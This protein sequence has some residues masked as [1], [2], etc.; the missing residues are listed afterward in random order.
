[1]SLIAYR[2]PYSIPMNPVNVGIIGLG[3]MG[4][5]YLNEF[6]KSDRWAVKTICELCEARHESIAA[7]A[8]EARIVT[9]E[10]EIFNDPEIQVVV[11][12]ALA[13]TRLRQIEKAV[14]AGK[15]IIAEKPIADTPENEWKAVELVESAPILSA[16][17]LYIRNSWYLN[18]LNECITSGEI[19][20]LAIVRICHMTPGLSPGEGH[21]AEGPAFHDCGMHYVD[22]ARWL[23]HSEYKTM[24]AQAVRMW[25]Y[26]DP[27]WLQCQGT[28]ENG[29]VFDITQ[30]H[31]YGQLSDKQTHNS[32]MDILGSKGIVRM[33]HDFK[34]AVVEVHG[35]TRTER[36]ER[37]YG[38]KNIGT[39]IDIFADCLEKGTKDNRL[40]SFRD[41][42]VASEFA[43]ECLK[44][45][46]NH[47]MPVKGTSEELEQIH[48]RRRTMKDGYGL[49]HK[50]TTR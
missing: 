36:I 40:P 22:V 13:D 1:M 4:G 29:V 21:E 9:D 10:D 30:S 48:H 12:A 8:P 32:Y 7:R 42:A 24:R 28:F 38:G 25:E 15:H 46:W 43:W 31:A 37:P 18:E 23:A 5:F 6:Q 16:V 17:N 45:A 14:A 27:W 2:E 50:Q 41:S 35:V 33:T 20:E 47:D 49:L 34:T 39:L 26:K 3:R 11:L 19:G 44:D